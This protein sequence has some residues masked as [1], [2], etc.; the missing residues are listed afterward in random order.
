MNKI[1]M[2]KFVRE[3]KEVVDDHYLG[4]GE[5][6]RWL[7]QDEKGGRR[8]GVNEYGCADAA[9]ILYTID[10]FGVCHF[11]VGLPFVK[12]F[13]WPA[14]LVPGNITEDIS[15]IKGD[16]Q[17]VVI[18]GSNGIVG[19]SAHA[20]AD[21]DKI[22]VAL[23]TEGGEKFIRFANN[24][25]AAYNQLYVNFDTDVFTTTGEYNVSVT[26]RFAED[27]EVVDS[28]RVGT[29]NPLR[30]LLVRMASTGKQTDAF[31]LS[32]SDY[33]AGDYTE[34]TTF[35][36]TV[37]YTHAAPTMLRILTFGAAGSYIDVLSVEVE[38]AN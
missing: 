2:S 31:T 16:Q 20:P 11:I 33:E 38:P 21:A 8:L 26:L 10:E 30:A 12:E 29:A 34:W 13:A 32:K 24:G 14:V 35:E 17:K 3:V 18:T 1:D 37:N 28:A 15:G 19:L 5:Y 25:T 23:V 7:W 6:C 22:S 4:N 27:H 9:N 36:F